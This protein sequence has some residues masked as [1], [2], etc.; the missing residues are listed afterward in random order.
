MSESLRRDTRIFIAG[1]KGLVGS[2]LTR[3]FSRNGFTHLILKGREHYDL[4]DRDQVKRLF[5]IERPDVVI[6]A[7]AKVGGIWA[8]Q[9]YPYD[10]VAR[11]LKIQLNL[12]DEAHRFGVERLLFLGSSCIYPKMAPQPIR[13]DSILTGPLEP[14]NRPY[15]LAKIAG[16]ELCW[17]LNRQFGRRYFCVMPTNLYGV[18]DNFDLR[19]SHVLPALIRKF[20]DAKRSDSDHVVVWGSGTPR[21]EFLFSDDLAE[22]ILFLLQTSPEKLNFLYSENSAPLINIGYGSDITIRELAEIVKKVVGYTGEI[23]TDES[24]P[25]GTPRKLMDSTRMGTLGWRPKVSLEEGVRLVYRAFA[26]RSD[27][28]PSL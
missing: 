26:A 18:E 21:R 11:N 2:A 4:E 23:R 24:H 14:S 15:A 17:S 28:G 12:I 3:V 16:I 9:N 22:G 19:T 13:E 10:F 6:D 27:N 25:D 7:A 8:N 5:E 1:H 20:H